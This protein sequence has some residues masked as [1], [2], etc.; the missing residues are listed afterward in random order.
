MLQKKE[1]DYLIFEIKKNAQ[2]MYGNDLLKVILYGSYAR[3]SYN[4]NSDLDIAFLLK[5]EYK[6]VAEL[7][8]IYDLLYDLILKYKIHISVILLKEEEFNNNNW[9]LYFNIKNE[10]IE[11]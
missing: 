10:G 5:G 2:M 1:I 4:E 3:A 8:K 9:P 6:K 7:N 11:V